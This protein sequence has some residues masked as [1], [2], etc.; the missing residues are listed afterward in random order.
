MSSMVF[1]ASGIGSFSD[2]VQWYGGGRPLSLCTLPKS[3]LLAIRTNSGCIIVSVQNCFQSQYI[4]HRQVRVSQETPPSERVERF[5][6]GERHDGPC[7][8]GGIRPKSPKN[9]QTTHEKDSKTSLK[10]SRC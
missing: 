4:L 3:Q 2:V 8:A 6:L 1:I 10:G 7:V 9:T 5:P